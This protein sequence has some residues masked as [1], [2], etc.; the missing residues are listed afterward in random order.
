MT[1]ILNWAVNTRKSIGKNIPH[2]HRQ[3]EVVKEQLY[4]QALYQHLSIRSTLEAC[5]LKWLY[6]ESLS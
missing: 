6:D 2:R 1:D 3:R 5:F 4:E